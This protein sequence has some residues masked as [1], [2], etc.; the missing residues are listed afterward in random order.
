MLSKPARTKQLPS[1]SWPPELNQAHEGRGPLSE[2]RPRTWLMTRVS[3]GRQRA[4]GR[5]SKENAATIPISLHDCGSLG[6]LKIRPGSSVS[7]AAVKRGEH[8]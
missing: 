7:S 8:W 2:K 5:D 3:E 1:S 4:E 6:V